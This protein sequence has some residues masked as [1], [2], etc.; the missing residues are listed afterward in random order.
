MDIKGII[1]RAK[2]NREDRGDTPLT[3]KAIGEAV[4]RSIDAVY[5]WKRGEKVML[6]S[7]PETLALTLILECSLYELARAF[8]CT[9]SDKY[10]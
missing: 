10:P 1:E 3:D 5:S 8:D 2:K 9:Y 6:L 4:G 7:P